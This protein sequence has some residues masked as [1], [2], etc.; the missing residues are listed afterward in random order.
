MLKSLNVIYIFP[1][2]EVA[3]IPISVR[4]TFKIAENVLDEIAFETNFW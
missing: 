1:S 2:I 4:S 3:K